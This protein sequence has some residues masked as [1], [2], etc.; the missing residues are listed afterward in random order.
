VSPGGTLTS[1]LLE[2]EAKRA[3]EFLSSD[4]HESRRLAAVLVLKELAKS[5]PTPFYA[6]L[7][8]VLDVIW[9]PLRDPKVNI[10]EAA[11]ECLGACLEILAHRDQVRQ[12]LSPR[13]LEEAQA[14]LRSNSVEMIHGSLLA[15]R[16]L[17]LR[18]GVFVN[19]RYSDVCEII[20]RHR[21]H[22][23]ALIRRTVVS[24]IPRL[25]EY[26]PEQFVATYFPKCMNHLLLQLKKEKDRSAAYIAI[27]QV[28]I[29][30]G[31][32]ILR[33]LDPIVANIKDGLSFA[34]KSYK[35]R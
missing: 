21:D 9:T 1:D 10:R 17:L 30:V 14:G 29:A 24:L 5:S 25:A 3:L 33:Y 35:S 15:Y 28:A 32:S 19:E 20:L 12:Q 2:F 18:S 7:P 4:R 13:M 8:S 31:G 34:A 23:D 6:Y 16:E 26:N 11:A 22:R 27:G